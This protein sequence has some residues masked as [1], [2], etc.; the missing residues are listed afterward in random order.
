MLGNVFQYDFKN[1]ARYFLPMYL[2]F[3]VLMLLTKLYFLI[4]PA[5]GPLSNALLSLMISSYM[6]GVFAM[7]IL[8]SVF[9]IYHFYRKCI[10]SEG[11]LTFTL[12]VSTG[13]HL[14]SKCLNGAVWQLFT[15]LLLI[16]SIFLLFPMDELGRVLRIIQ[17]ILFSRI[18]LDLTVP[19][20]FLSLTLVTQFFAGPLMFYASMAVGQM[21]ARR[22]V[23][24]SIGLYI[25]LYMVISLLSSFGFSFLILGSEILS[26]G[27]IQTT[28]TI[29]SIAAFALALAETVLFY[30]LTWFFLDR[31]LNLS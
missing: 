24:A 16:L 5:E 12:P 2:I 31:K 3:A 15:Y 27:D 28:L 18:S 25:G 8:T 23:L 22:K 30:F 6:F 19:M 1:C 13:T 10:S 14:V 20:I 17:Y 29:Y 7:A 4:S 11:Y 26:G 21:A 9:L